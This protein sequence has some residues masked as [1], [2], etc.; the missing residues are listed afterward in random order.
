MALSEN[1]IDSSRV[2]LHLPKMLPTQNVT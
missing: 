1:H 2:L